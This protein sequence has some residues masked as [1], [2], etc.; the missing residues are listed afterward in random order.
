MCPFLAEGGIGSAW[1]AMFSSQHVK[2]L[3]RQNIFYSSSFRDF[4][5]QILA[6]LTH[7]SPS[8]YQPY[9]E[10]LYAREI[11]FLDQLPGFWELFVTT[12]YHTLS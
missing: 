6:L 3:Q 4:G 7:P 11:N 8:P 5:D 9:L 10:T 12:V 1:A 2:A